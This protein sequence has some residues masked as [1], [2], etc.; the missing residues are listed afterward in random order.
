MNLKR[1]IETKWIVYRQNIIMIFKPIFF[2]KH[3][4]TEG[5]KEKFS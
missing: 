1:E 2:I 3:V 4:K 5:R